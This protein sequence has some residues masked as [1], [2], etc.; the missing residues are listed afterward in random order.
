MNDQLTD[1]APYIRALAHAFYAMH[2][3]LIE[4]GSLQPGEVS[5]TLRS[6]DPGPEAE[7]M[8]TA[9]ILRAMARNLDDH[10]YGSVGSARNFGV[11]DGGKTE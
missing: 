4:S 10:V 3:R 8:L 5:E 9:A 6:L 7:S 2:A 1:A 11:I